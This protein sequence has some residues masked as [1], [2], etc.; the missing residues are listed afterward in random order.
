MNNIATKRNMLSV[1]IGSALLIP[2]ANAA[3]TPWLPQP[4]GG[5]VDLAYVFQ[6]ADEFYIADDKN[7]LPDDLE[8]ATWWISVDYG[9]SENIAISAKTG[10]ARSTFEPEANQHLSGRTDSQIGVRYRFNDEFT[11]PEGLPSAAIRITGIIEGNYR[12]GSIHSIGDGA[13]G[14]EAALSVGKIFNDYFALSGEIGYRNRSSGVPEELFYR[15]DAFVVPLPGLTANVSYFAA[16]A[17][18]GLDIGGAGFSPDRFHELEEDTSAV[19]TGINYSLT[20]ELNLGVQYATVVDGR[21]TA[22]SDIYSANI[23]FSF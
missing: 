8:Q 18:D 7:D 23:G 17:D 15:L 19:S 3:N 22:R 4:G 21:N 20:P 13:D 6:S 14:I 2:L 9:L 16:D 11:G 1:I 5:Q 10:Y 12:T